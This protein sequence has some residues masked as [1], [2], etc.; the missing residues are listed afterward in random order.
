MSY[1]LNWPQ[2]ANHASKGG[3]TLHIRSG[4]VFSE[5][6]HPGYGQPP[7]SFYTRVILHNKPKNVVVLSEDHLNPV[8]A[9]L[10][11]WCQVR[12]LLVTQISSGLA[13]T[14]S[15]LVAAEALAAGRGT[16]VPAALSLKPKER[17]IYLFEP[18]SEPLLCD[19]LN[20][21]Y[22]VRDADGHYAREI[23]NHNWN[24]T[25]AQRELMVSYP[26]TSLSDVI[27]RKS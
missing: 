22:E 4:D 19:Q 6:P 14:V 9:E 10:V 15:E 23:L 27:K 17:D 24:N 21:I 2:S 1:A 11:S 12:G 3:L 18:G 25:P 8:V 13:S 5:H 20:K 16:F 26:E 7:L